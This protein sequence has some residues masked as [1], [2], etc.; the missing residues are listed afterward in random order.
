[1]VA[2]AAPAA[3]L[4]RAAATTTKKA[5]AAPASAAQIQIRIFLYG[6]DSG[7]KYNHS[8]NDRY[9]FPEILAIRRALYC[10][11]LQMKKYNYRKFNRI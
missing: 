4:E 10:G 5:P 11:G 6:S 9:R 8:K 2:A 3:A 7:K 1:V